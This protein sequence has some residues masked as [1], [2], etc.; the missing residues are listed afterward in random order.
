MRM[1][2]AHG[3]AETIERA[4]EFVKSGMWLDYGA[5]TC[6]PDVSDHAL[7]RRVDKLSNI[8]IRS[9]LTL[10]PRA[11]LEADPN[12]ERVLS[13]N[14]HFSGNDRQR[15]DAGGC[16]YLPINFGEVPDY[17]RRFVDPVDIVVIKACPSDENGFFNL[18]VSGLYHRALI[19]RARMVIIETNSAL[20]YVYGDSI[21]IHV[22]EVDY[23]IEGD[24]APPPA[25]PNAPVSD[26]DRAIA[27][28]IAG[29]VEDGACLQ[30]GIGG[31]PNA[32]CTLLLESGVRDLGVHS[33]MM[34]E[35]MVELYKAG[36]ITGARKTVDRGKH[37]YSFALGPVG[38]YATLDRNPDMRA[39]PLEYTN[40]P[41]MIMQNEKVVAINAT[42]QI[43]LQGQ[44]PRNPTAT[45]ISA[46]PA[47]RHSSCAAPTLL[48]AAS[49]SSACLRQTTDAASGAAA[50]YST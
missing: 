26:I 23:V 42:T 19:E 12:S 20:P 16:V 35:S 15:H 30:I 28:T 4:A 32:V 21:G 1:R 29:E 45:G 47:V 44:Q 33:E 14:M 11:V 50:L 8:K 48:K 39:M 24:N 27:R 34:A 43:D 6:Q 22:S 17:Y 40:L 5:S 2:V 46:V 9:C 49:P 37:V 36:R 41:H 18:S 10:K 31:T 25:L 38:L 7:A 13:V 3:R